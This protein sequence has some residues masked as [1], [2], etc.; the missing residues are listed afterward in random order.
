MKEYNDEVISK[1]SIEK[2]RETS[3]KPSRVSSSIN[4]KNSRSQSS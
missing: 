2:K 4:S 3:V 1:S